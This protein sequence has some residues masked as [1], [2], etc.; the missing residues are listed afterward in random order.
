M[1]TQPTSHPSL[2]HRDYTQGRKQCLRSCNLRERTITTAVTQVLEYVAPQV[3]KALAAKLNLTSLLRLFRA[4]RQLFRQNEP[5]YR[6]A[7]SLVGQS[8][9]LHTAWLM[10]IEPPGSWDRESQTRRT[11]HSHSEGRSSNLTLSSPLPLYRLPSTAQ[12]RRYLQGPR[13]ATPDSAWKLVRAAM[14]L[15]QREQLA[16]RSSQKV[17]CDP[18]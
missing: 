1:S 5:K 15:K 6:R 2:G 12:V 9:L 14:F 17:V 8:R 11:R 10:V 13:W 16:S 18:L 7:L 3:C 4:P